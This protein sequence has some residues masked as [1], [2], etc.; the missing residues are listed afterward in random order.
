[1]EWLGALTASNL[2]RNP[3]T[4]ETSLGLLTPGDLDGVSQMKEVN[5]L[6]SVPKT[7]RD[8][9]ARK[10]NKEENRE[11][12]SRFGF[13][14]FDGP[15]EQGYGGYHYDGRWVAVAERIIDH[16]DL[17]PGDNVLDVGCAKGFL[18][19]DLMHV[20]PSLHIY[21]VDI[22]SYALSHAETDARGNLI[23]GS[24][25][26]LP[27]PDDSFAAA[28]AINTIHNLHRDGCIQALSELERIA[29]G[30]SF[31]QVDAYRSESERRIF[32]DWMLT[33]NTYLN[34]DGWRVMFQ[35]S[36][37]TGDYFWT[38]LEADERIVG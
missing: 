38:I 36:G 19:K 4:G 1:M 15:R 26:K 24:C 11:I 6:A 30:K 22:S 13:E 33:A 31:V 21:G 16:F 5:L 8:V 17:D 10:K 25:D 29:P 14:Y 27:F 35:E 9:G 18:V 32:E 34:P 20:M 12:A 3:F 2:K 7:V 28:L 23:L 37:Y